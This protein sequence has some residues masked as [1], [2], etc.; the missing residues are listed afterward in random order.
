MS[1]HWTDTAIPLASSFTMNEHGFVGVVC[2][3]LLYVYGV[4]AF[5]VCENS[6]S[7]AE[8]ENSKRY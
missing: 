5:I 1:D 8:G 3:F 6:S 2:L 4:S 7:T